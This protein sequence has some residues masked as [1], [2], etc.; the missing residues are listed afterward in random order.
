MTAAS[1]SPPL[2]P[3]PHDAGQGVRLFR[4]KIGE[5]NAASIGLFKKLGYSE[6]SFSEYFKE[7][8]LELPAERLQRA[9][10]PLVLGAFDVS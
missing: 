10:K 9:G 1:P 7:H 3:S 2:P 4:A 6:T 5:K 8:C